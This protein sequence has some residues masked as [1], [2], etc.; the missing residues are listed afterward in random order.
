MYRAP[1]Q[2]RRVSAAELAWVRSDAEGA[3]GSVRGRRLLRY[4]GTW[5]FVLGKTMTDPVWY[6]Y[7]FWLPKFLDTRWGVHLS[8]LAAP[9]V[10]IYVVAG[11]GSVAGGWSS[12]ALIGRGWAV[13]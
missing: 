5:A 10:V 3:G 12:S 8:A 4:R 7:L 2:H 6:F 11:V 1:E 13:N 9:L